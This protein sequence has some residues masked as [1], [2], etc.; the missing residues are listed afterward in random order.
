MSASE[1]TNYFNYHIA[2]DPHGTQSGVTVP[3]PAL[4][5]PARPTPASVPQTMRGGGGGRRSIAGGGWCVGEQLT[6][7][8]HFFLRAALPRL[9]SKP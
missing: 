8:A 5:T 9:N 7:E 3:L 2:H 6:P 1:W 4:R